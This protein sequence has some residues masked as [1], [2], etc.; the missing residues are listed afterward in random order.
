MKLLLIDDSRD[1]SLALSR[2]LA[3]L[4]DVVTA[5][6][7]AEGLSKA[8]TSDYTCIVL[9]LGLPDMHGL[10]VCRKI[11][12]YDRTTPIIILSGETKVLTKIALMDMGADDYLT[13]PFSLGELK[14][15]LRALQRRAEI[16][17]SR[18]QKI[19][20]I[21]LSLDS[22]RHMVERSGTPIKLRKKEFALLEC[23]MHNAGQV[24]SRQALCNYAWHDGQ[25]PW[26]NT[27]DVHIKYLRD[28]IDKPFDEALIRTVHGLGYKLEL[29]RTV[30]ESA[31][32]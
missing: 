8:M 22:Q 9:D 3:S 5:R 12:D 18:N 30:T 1:I 13:K 10:E 20:F 15:R 17:A 14:V 26:T 19:E 28:K 29:P 25:E 4:Y 16:I 31:R 2:A 7:G 24:V 32:A 6:T 21:G 11:R 27:V 23:L